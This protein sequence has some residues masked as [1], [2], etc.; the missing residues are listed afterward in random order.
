MASCGSHEREKRGNKL[1]KVRQYIFTAVITELR[2][3][4]LVLVEKFKSV[5]FFAA[6]PAVLEYS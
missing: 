3:G 5:L 1:E 4:I 6:P 2:T